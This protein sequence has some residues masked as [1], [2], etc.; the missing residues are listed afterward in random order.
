MLALKSVTRER[1][2]TA[3][4]RSPLVLEDEPRERYARVLFTPLKP[5]DADTKFRRDLPERLHGRGRGFRI[6][7]C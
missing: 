7:S 5:R 4:G 1:D 3:N 2:C 6:Q